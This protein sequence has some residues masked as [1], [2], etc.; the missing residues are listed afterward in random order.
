[1][2][3]TWFRK[4]GSEPKAT[5]MYGVVQPHA[6]TNRQDKMPDF[7]CCQFTTE[8]KKEKKKY[9]MQNFLQLSMYVIGQDTC[10]CIDYICVKILLMTIKCCKKKKGNNAM[11][12]DWYIVSTFFASFIFLICLKRPCLFLSKWNLWKSDFANLLA[13]CYVWIF[14][15]LKKLI[16]LQIFPYWYLAGWIAH[17]HH[18]ELINAAGWSHYWSPQNPSTQ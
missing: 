11:C 16:C 13:T 1:M 9:C 17:Y 5:S 18:P 10:H 12:Q 7:L 15:I 4:N 8:K 3:T 6:Y 2:S 14:W